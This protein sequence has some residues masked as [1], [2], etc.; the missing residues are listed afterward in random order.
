[1]TRS[2]SEAVHA[3]CDFC[4]LPVQLPVKPAG[5]TVASDV[6]YC[7]LGCRFAAEITRE[8]GE[9]GAATWT[10]TRLG[11]GIFFTM[12]VMAFTMAL[13]TT[14]LYQAPNDHRL[15]DSM[16]GLLRYLCLLF[17]LP[18]LFLLGKPLFESAWDGLRRRIYSTDLLLA[19]GVLAA[20]VYSS[21]SVLRDQGE[22]Y[23]E[24][25]CVVLVMLTLGRWFEATGKLKAISAL[26]ELEKLFPE[27]AT[28]VE[29]D[30]E[31]K[32]PVSDIRPEMHLRVLP[33]GRFPTDGKLLSST[34]TV[35]Q[36]VL[37]GESWPVVLMQG[38]AVLG[39]TLN[40]DGNVLMQA[41]SSAAS[42]TFA[43]VVTVIREARLSKGNYQRWADR[44]S[45]IFM[46][47]VSVL[48]IAST[49]FHAWIFGLDRGLMV[50][51][52]VLLIACPCALGLAT[53]LAVWIGLGVA[54]SRQVLFRGGES[55]ERLASIRAI[56]FDKTGTLT[57]GKPKVT[58][59]EFDPDCD[60]PQ[61]ERLARLLASG[62]SHVLSRAIL[63]FLPDSGC[64][65]GT[66]QLKQI[67]GR[68]VEAWV[69]EESTVGSVSSPRQYR[70]F[71]GSQNWIRLLGIPQS[72]EWEKRLSTSE[73]DDNSLAI[74]ADE[75]GI[76][77][78]FLFHEQERTGTE[79]LFDWCREESLDTAVLTGDH[80]GKAAGLERIWGV[81]VI[82][83]LLP[84]DK[85]REIRRLRGQVGPVA[86]VG[87]G[88]NDGPALALADVGISLRSGTD[89]SRESSGVCLLSDDLRLIRWSRDFSRRV[90][91]TIQF[92]LLWA[93]GYNILGMV[94]ACLGWMNPAFAAL[95]M[96]VS[97]LLVIGNSLALKQ[98]LPEQTTEITSLREIPHEDFLET[99]GL[100][101]PMRE[102]HKISSSTTGGNL[103]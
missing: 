38:E 19:I 36:Q 94:L 15:A 33:G 16:N 103:V 57:T 48:A 51:L 54:A 83:N 99:S 27:F 69:T 101:S 6:H 97:S 72:A 85:L 79:E 8:K 58:A 21:I 66:A 35:D 78:L 45:S 3:A 80:S 23:F 77:A 31:L 28:L 17:S 98:F 90:V 9:T 56:R 96:V 30:H 26:D 50:G 49:I 41:T 24:V 81:P 4:G 74:L 43:R 20:F 86:M 60:R 34:V 64:F 65:D 12:N 52:S 68:G 102:G 62:S 92:N 32:I 55:L 87:D 88:I 5:K 47:L 75:R 82:G 44:V 40:L 18:V 29:H 70:V 13:W 7:C 11:L 93:F 14:A 71:L 10:M 37:T 46:P 22:V 53:P 1:M 100:S 63:D 42:G 25:G 76:L 2:S 61:T 89:L 59:C 67:A 95:L 84:E 91:R 39:G 73:C